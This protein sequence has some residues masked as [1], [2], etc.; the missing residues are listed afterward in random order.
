[1]P[2]TTWLLVADPNDLS[3]LAL[4]VSGRLLTA[5]RLDGAG[6]IGRIQVSQVTTRAITA[7]TRPATATQ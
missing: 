3:P 7:T 1:M 2:Y 4:L 6:L 5:G